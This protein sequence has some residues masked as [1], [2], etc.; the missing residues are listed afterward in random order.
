[1]QPSGDFMQVLNEDSNLKAWSHRL[2]IIP[3]SFKVLEAAQGS[4]ELDERSD[5]AVRRACATLCTKMFI[6][7][8]KTLTSTARLS[9]YLQDIRFCAPGGASFPPS[10]EGLD[11]AAKKIQNSSIRTA[12]PLAAIVIDLQSHLNLDTQSLRQL[13]DEDK[14]W[15]TRREIV[16]DIA[17][18][19]HR[20]LGFPMTIV[21]YDPMA[22]DDVP[23]AD[24]KE[25][26]IVPHLIVQH[27]DAG[28]MAAGFYATPHLSN[29]VVS[30]SR[31][32]GWIADFILAL[33]IKDS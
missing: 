3:R 6:L 12:N 11:A 32:S 14:F 9:K 16:K 10:S 27:Y 30:G 1:M 31:A 17:L 4:L 8:A 7:C 5:Q 33:D 15:D 2:L 21:C 18:T 24:G 29:T 19:L 22:D 23:G 28:E 20:A 25:P 13:V 26:S